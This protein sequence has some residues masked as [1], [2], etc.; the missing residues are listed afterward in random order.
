MQDGGYI[1]E[2]RAN[3]LKIASLADWKYFYKEYVDAYE[4]AINFNE[5][6]HA[7]FDVEEENRILNFYS[8]S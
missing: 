1:N 4:Q 6:Y 2:M 7:K 3:S 5:I 8:R